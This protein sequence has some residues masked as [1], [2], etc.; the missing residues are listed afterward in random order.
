MDRPCFFLLFLILMGSCM[1]DID[2]DISTDLQIEGNEIFDISLSLEESL[3]FP[4][5]SIDYFR[6]AESLEIPGCPDVTID[7]THKKVTLAFSV[8]KECV[9][10]LYVP[11][12]GKIHLQYITNTVL[13]STVSVEYEDYIVRGIKIEGKRD[14][15]RANSLLNP[16]RR[17]ETF[18]DLFIID[19][20]NS[21]SR[22]NGSF[23][24]QLVIL[25]GILT[26]FSSTGEIEG[27]NIAGRPINMTQTAVKNYNV[28]CIKNGF[29]LPGQGS[30]NWQIIRNE[31][32]ATKHKVV[33]TL[34]DQCN[35]TATITLQD[36]R[37]MVF[38]L[39]E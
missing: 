19:E 4:F 35:A 38:R 36:G 18:Q 26:G 25:N 11:R 30:G 1:G 14:F 8:K 22:I 28:S 33:Y 34:E 37:L 13:E 23:I 16:N 9:N 20:H 29:L 5:Q 10:S 31:T 6:L 12:S 39:A 24:H 7:E 32:Q 3:F 21:T 15:K 27:R 2:K 17:A